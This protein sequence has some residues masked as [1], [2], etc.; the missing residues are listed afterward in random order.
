MTH[1]LGR[2]KIGKT[3]V[4]HFSGPTEQEVKESQDKIQGQSF[5]IVAA[6]VKSGG[7]HTFP[8]Q[9]KGEASYNFSCA[10]FDLFSKELVTFTGS[11]N[12][13]HVITITEKCVKM[14]NEMVKEI[15]AGK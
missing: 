8:L 15:K 5:E 1:F 12:E 4:L 6:C 3:T 13:P 7:T 11:C 14:L 10:L 2:E 9:A